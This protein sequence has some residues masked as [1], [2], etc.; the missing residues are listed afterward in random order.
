MTNVGPF[1]LRGS[2]APPCPLQSAPLPRQA[3]GNRHRGRVAP[4]R[5]TAQR[6]RGK[7]NAA[8]PCP[9]AKR[10]DTQRPRLIF[11]QI[12]QWR[13]PCS[14]PTRKAANSLSALRVVR[15][16]LRK[17]KRGIL[18]PR[19]SRARLSFGFAWS[20]GEA[21]EWPSFDS[22][23]ERAG[24]ATQKKPGPRK[25]QAPLKRRTTVAKPV[26]IYHRL[27]RCRR[28]HEHTPKSARRGRLR[29]SAP[30]SSSGRP[31]HQPLPSQRQ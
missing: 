16:R 19:P 3:Q 9:P 4:Q 1:L 13:G 5:D 10:P 23:C 11:R 8:S 21:E 28:R 2:P 18:S 27:R 30:E 29:R 20:V 14:K 15:Q 24:E 7:R 25:G 22:G 31:A 26:A 17:G 12:V 6:G